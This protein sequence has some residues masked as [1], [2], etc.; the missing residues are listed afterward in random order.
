MG[1]TIFDSFGDFN[2]PNLVAVKRVGKSGGVLLT[3]PVKGYSVHYILFL[4]IPLL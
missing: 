4:Q 3:F 2:H 1:E